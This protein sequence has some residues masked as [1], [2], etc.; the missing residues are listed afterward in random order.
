[1]AVITQRTNLA[2]GLGTAFGEGLTQGYEEEVDRRAL[3]NAIGRL[4]PNAS[5]QEILKTLVG[6]K[7]SPA[8]K[9]EVF[10]NLMGAA[11]F[12]QKNKQF[13]QEQEAKTKEAIQKK[14]DEELKAQEKIKAEKQAVADIVDAT[15]GLTEEQKAQYRGNLNINAAQSL[16]N[17]QMKQVGKAERDKA[18]E[19]INQKTVQ[20]S[21]D[22]MVDLIPKIGRSRVPGSYLGGDIAKRFSQFTSLSGALE[23]LLVEKVNRGTLAKERFK[24]ITETLLPKPSDS[25]ADIEGKL[26]GLAT[27]LELDPGKLL[28][29]PKEQEKDESGRPP[30]SSFK[31]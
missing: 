13:Q 5:P 31:R 4:P 19:E 2:P 20:K 8:A 29:K 1:M 7:A 23:S 6:T 28:G 9:Q 24:Y 17:E 3:Q 16:F 21:F 25:Q 27:M 30:L 14:V 11:E 10:K 18:E 22:E 15:P 12:E 26:L